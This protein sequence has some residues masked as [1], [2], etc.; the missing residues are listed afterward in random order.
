MKQLKDKVKI[1]Q[2]FNTPST[3]T[4]TSTL[5][6]A[7]GFT[8]IE[9]MVVIAI[10]SMIAMLVFPRLPAS[11]SSNLRSSARSLATL[12]RYLGDTAVTTKG[13]YQMRTVMGENVLTVTRDKGGEATAASDPFLNRRFLAEGV[14]IADVVIP[15]LGRVNSG[16]VLI[17]FS[18]EGL[19]EL[20][21]FHLKGAA[22][23]NF[24]VIAFPHNG[25]VKVLE[26][27]QE[28]TL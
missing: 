28:L 10:L 25:K 2:V 17:E 14:T 8:L 19:G 21:T 12:I 13:R 23:N 27:Y 20:V 3:L 26:G 6:S 4:S 24:T 9:L 15:R 5:T 22:G 1:E 18:T 11:D 7:S 16:E